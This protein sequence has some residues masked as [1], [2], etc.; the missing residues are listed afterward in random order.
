MLNPMAEVWLDSCNFVGTEF[1]CEY[2]MCCH[3]I[4]RRADRPDM[5]MVQRGNAWIASASLRD[6]HKI[7]DAAHHPARVAFF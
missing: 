3:G 5:K 7:Y 2:K 4:F 1:L 6:F